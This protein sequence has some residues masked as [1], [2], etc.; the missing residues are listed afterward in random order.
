MELGSTPAPAAGFDDF[1]GS[2]FSGDDKNIAAAKYL[3]DMFSYTRIDDSNC[4]SYIFVLLYFPLGAMLLFI[5]IVVFLPLVCLACSI[6]CSPFCLPRSVHTVLM[7]FHFL[8]YFGVNICVTGKPDKDARIWVANHIS[9][10]DALAIRSIADPHI[11]GYSFYKDLWW[12]QLSPLG[13]MNMI[14]VPQQSRTDGNSSGRDAINQHI[15]D[16]LKTESKFILLFP[17]GGLTN[18]STA[19]LQYH[20]FVF[21][22]GKRVQPITLKICS[23]LPV[24][25]DTGYASFLSNIIWF[26]FM[27]FQRYEVGFLPAADIAENESALDFTRRVMAVTAKNLNMKVSPFL[28][29]DKRKWLQV[30]KLM[31]NNGHNFAFQIDQETGTVHVSLRA[32]PTTKKASSKQIAPDIGT[33]GSGAD[34]PAVTDR[35]LFLKYIHEAWGMDKEGFH[36]I[37][38][39]TPSSASGRSNV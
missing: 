26:I 29:S 17:E 35:D 2:S 27:P 18:T 11:L 13:L 36:H 12:L 38:F 19:L 16:L 39:S 33:E 22:L 21:G 30:K 4:C 5:R 28:Y 9:E 8:V 10:F 20:K 3:D 7:R 34:L 6:R 32:S 25:P 15:N 31:I 23:P 37:I 14:Y 24:N 1:P